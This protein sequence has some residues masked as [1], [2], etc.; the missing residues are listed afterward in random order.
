MAEQRLRVSVAGRDRTADIGVA[1][2]REAG[3]LGNS[4]MENQLSAEK[5][6]LA[7]RSAT[8]ATAFQSR[9]LGALRGRWMVDP[10]CFSTPSGPGVIGALMLQV[11][12]FLW[13][14]FRYQHD[15]IVFHQNAVNAQLFYALTFECEE[16]AR[17]VRELEARVQVLE[18][19]VGTAKTT[20]DPGS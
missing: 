11:R 9:H 17:Q 15:W 3:G 10:G 8:S 5:D 18:A 14:M 12:I 6:V 4:W 2:L 1:V 13:R 19:H 7:L 16:R 20:K